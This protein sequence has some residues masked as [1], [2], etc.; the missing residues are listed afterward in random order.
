M[1][2]I[3]F[4][5]IE[6]VLLLAIIALGAF[7]YLHKLGE[8][9]PGLYL[10]EAGTGYNAYSLLKT[11]KDEYGMAFP[12]AMRLFGSYT[13]PL[14]IYLS[15]PLI[16]LFGLKVFSVRLLSAICGVLAIPVIFL[17]IKELQITKSK[18]TPLLSSLFFTITPW[19][20]FYSR[21]GYEQNLAFLF[22][23]FSALL[24]VKSLKK[25]K[26]LALAI[27]VLSLA[28]YADYAQRFLAPI[29]LAGSL[30]LFWKK[31]LNKKYIK[32]AIIG[33][34]V[35]FFIQLP[36]L[37]LL[38][39][40]S[41]YT[42]TDHFYSEVIKAQAEKINHFLP[43]AIAV[44][45]AFVREFTSK[46]A[47]YYSPRS[48][49][50]LPD[51]DP[52]R[53]TPEL[54][55]FYPWMVIPYL[56]GLYFLW[57]TKKAPS[58]KLIFFLLLLTPLPGT[59]THEPFHVQRT[60]GLLLPT[61]LVIAIGIDKL[62]NAKRIK[63]WLPV[64]LFFL[65]TSLILLWRSYFVLLPQE[66]AVIWGYGYPHLAQIIKDNPDKVYVIDQ[67]K[68]PKP[69]DI[70]YIQ[71]AFYL[72]LP[73]EKLQ[74]YYGNEVT[75]GYY[76]KTEVT[77]THKFANI[78]TKPIDWGEAVWRDVIL[79]GDLVAISDPEVKLHNLTQVFE[80]KDPNNQIIYRG[81]QT[82]PKPK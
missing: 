64:A 69:Q 48:L 16:T 78:E 49:F 18:F 21:M 47:T 32:Y 20:V 22:L 37:T 71:L 65:G 27:P 8:T 73:P 23:A 50:F 7:L 9:P 1:Q 15:I 77:F 70:A 10:D 24:I 12:A 29:F 17:I 82:N 74:A 51:P 26:L 39:T 5:K 60:L 68:R 31:L 34:V 62:I 4:T 53:S 46:T 72:N 44:P 61:T 63:F 41:F 76:T 40:A 66:R 19:A 2:S 52:Q 35:A 55:V 57:K 13:P 54:S 59:L 80:I 79:V 25:P 3:K 42:K 6:P 81:F 56:I 58:S 67:S 45:L 11:G 30:V 33:G 28:T 36:N 43:P 14:H 75:G 38:N